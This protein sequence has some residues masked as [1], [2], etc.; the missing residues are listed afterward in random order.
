MH[1]KLTFAHIN[2]FGKIGQ[3]LTLVNDCFVM[4]NLAYEDG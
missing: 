3:L 4:I 2:Q 1:L